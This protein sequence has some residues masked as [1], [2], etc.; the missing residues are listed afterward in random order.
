MHASQRVQRL[1]AVTLV[2]N[3]AVDWGGF[4]DGAGDHRVPT[5][6]GGGQATDPEGSEGSLRGDGQRSSGGGGARDAA[7]SSFR[8]F[9]LSLCLRPLMGNS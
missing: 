7:H 3:R 1:S 8:G 2:V 5:G 6:G 4:Q 9:A